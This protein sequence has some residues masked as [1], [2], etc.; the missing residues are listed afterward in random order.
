[1]TLINVKNMLAFFYKSKSRFILEIKVVRFSVD[2]SYH[3]QLI[4]KTSISNIS[5]QHIIPNKWS[6]KT[7]N[8]CG[9]FNT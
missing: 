5:F 1:M 7:G 8:F 6:Y 4:A 9:K 3:I 2:M